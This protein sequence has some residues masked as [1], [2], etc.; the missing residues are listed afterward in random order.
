[1]VQNEMKRVY[2]PVAEMDGM[3]ILIDRLWPRGLSKEKAA[4]DAWIKDVAPRHELRRWFEHEP[5]KFAAFRIKYVEELREDEGKSQKVDE[6]CQL[7]CAKKLTILYGAKDR[8]HNHAVVLREELL[9]R[10]HDK[11]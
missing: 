4:L 11:K 6:L 8:V 10:I 3:R 9:H 2:D 5:E 7:A 1:M